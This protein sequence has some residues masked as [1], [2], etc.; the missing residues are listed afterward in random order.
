MLAAGVAHEIRTP[1][2]AVKAALFI[3]QKRFHSGT[4]EQA[5]ISQLVE[6]ELVAP[7]TRCQ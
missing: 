7:R 1:L 6:R 4:P 5:D 3:Q 2:T